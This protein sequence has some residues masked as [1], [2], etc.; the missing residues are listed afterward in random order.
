MGPYSGSKFAMEG[1]SHALRRELMLYG[2]DVI[3]IGPGAIK[4][5]IWTKTDNPPP[6]LAESPYGKSMGNLRKEFI[7]QEAKAMAVEVLADKVFKVFESPKPKTR[8]A[9]LNDK[10]TNFIIPR[11][12]PDRMLDKILKK[13]LFK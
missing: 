4:T 12:L 1:W 13:M 8:Y 3:I 6:H 10:L 11:A 2:I 9:F 5:P 7:K